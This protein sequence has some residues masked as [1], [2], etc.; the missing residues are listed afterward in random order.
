MIRWLSR[1]PVL[2]VLFVLFV[3]MTFAF[4]WVTRTYGIILLDGMW[5]PETVAANIAS[6]TDA[7]RF[8]HM[9]TTATL[10]VAYPVVYG[11][12]FAGL[13]LRFLG[14]L[15]AWAAAIC[16]AVIPVDLMEG[17]VQIMALSGHDGVLGA[18]SVLTPI[19][20]GLLWTGIAIAVL[21]LLWGM[22]T[23]ARRRLGR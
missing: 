6:M 13:A 19:K 2:L 23:L 5:R 9:M 3:G 18:K 16:L 17:A 22:F 11:G 12:L 7:Q 20:I 14:P 8:A 15:G 21:S 10:D 4:G 1:T